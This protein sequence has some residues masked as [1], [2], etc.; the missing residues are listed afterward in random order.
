[1]NCISVLR[2]MTTHIMHYR[3]YDLCAAEDMYIHEGFEA[4]INQN[5]NLV[6]LGC[7][8]SASS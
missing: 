3:Q 2:E 8:I 6:S 5:I 4:P 1:M 7:R